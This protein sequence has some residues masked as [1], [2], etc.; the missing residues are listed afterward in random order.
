MFSRK[1]LSDDIIGEEAGTTDWSK[2]F[3]SLLIGFVC[4]LLGVFFRFSVNLLSKATYLGALGKSDA[5]WNLPLMSIAVFLPL[6]ALISAWIVYHYEPDA[7][8]TG[9]AAYID[10]FHHKG[11]IIRP[12]VTVI[13]FIASTLNLG[14]GTSG[15]FEGPIV[16]MGAGAGSWIAQKIKTIKKDIHLYMVSGTA[17]GISAIF[18][19]PL[20]GALT[21]I[22]MLYREDYETRALVP[23]LLASVTGYFTA[24]LFGFTGFEVKSLIYAFRGISEIPAYIL[25]TLICSGAGWLFVKLFDLIRSISN[26]NVHPAFLYPF[27]GSLF[28]VAIGIFYPV[29]LGP[30]FSV[31]VEVLENYPGVWIIA[32]LCLA[33]MSATC[34]TIGP[35][36]SAGVFGPALIIGGF[37]G[38]FFS[39]F[40]TLAGFPFPVPDPQSM[41][42]VGMAGF[43]AAISKAPFG[44]VIMV[45]EIGGTFALLPP[46]LIVCL[47]SIVMTR[48]FTIY[49]TQVENRFK[50]PAHAHLMIQENHK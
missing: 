9:S 47:L 14:C 38:I 5:F 10:A 16:L 49:K 30:R 17:A 44:S 20:G 4:G 33:K 37:L 26:K 7:A 40:L 41:M 1:S 11:A 19:A 24:T 25:F 29:V 22:E 27:Y 12:R 36:G 34:L 21:A 32:V 31:L 48:N 23:A 18:L 28:V 39:R 15:G 8:G 6:A 45:C 43:F 35:G 3:Y 13:K 50:S 2:I 46:L 42:L